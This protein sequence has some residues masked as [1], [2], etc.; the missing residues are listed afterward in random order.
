MN[1]KPYNSRFEVLVRLLPETFFFRFVRPSSKVD[2]TFLCETLKRSIVNMAS[3]WD[4]GLVNGS[5]CHH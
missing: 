5:G 4:L 2:V 1:Q 3:N